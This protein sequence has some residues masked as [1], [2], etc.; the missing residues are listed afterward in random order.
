M[1]DFVGLCYLIL[2]PKKINLWR[3]TSQSMNY[4]AEFENAL[5]C[6][7]LG[8]PALGVSLWGF[9]TLSTAIVF[10]NT[11]ENNGKVVQMFAKNVSMQFILF[12]VNNYIFITRYQISSTEIQEIFY[13]WIC[14]WAARWLNYIAHWIL[15]Q[16]GECR[17]QGG[18]G[19]FAFCYTKECAA[20][21][22]M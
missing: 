5:Q 15:Y 9:V 20:S 4:S 13:A 1:S 19:H 3:L 12:A 2:E 7:N 16:V 8:Y 18:V 6:C 10:H 21:R 22:E 14:R 17:L 11:E